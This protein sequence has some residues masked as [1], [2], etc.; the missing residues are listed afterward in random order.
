MLASLGNNTSLH[1]WLRG[2]GMV[3]GEVSKVVS[4]ATTTARFGFL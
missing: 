4:A 1:P 2:E 3:A